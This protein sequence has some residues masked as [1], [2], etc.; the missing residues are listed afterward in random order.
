MNNA[1][2]GRAIVAAFDHVFLIALRAVVLVKRPKTTLRYMQLPHYA[3]P[4][5]PALPRTINDLFYWRKLFDDDPRFPIIADKLRV[6]DWLRERGIAV[7]TPEIA[8][9]GTDPDD[10][11]DALWSADYVLKANH[12]SGWNI[13]L[14]DHLPDRGSPT[15]LARRFIKQ[16]YGAHWQEP[17]YRDIEPKLYLER[18]IP[19]CPSEVKFYTIGDQVPRVF[20]SY[21]RDTDYKADIWTEDANGVLVL[22]EEFATSVEKRAGHPVP[23]IANEALAIAR[24][25]GRQFDHVRVDFL[26]DG[27]QF[28]FSELTLANLGGHMQGAQGPLID[29]ME[30]AWDIRRSWFMQTPQTGWRKWYQAAL[31]RRLEARQ[32]QRS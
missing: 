3:W 29:R 31:R 23:D 5:N 24:S 26:T 28:W 6:A 17:F 19:N 22:T 9:I 21:D 7:S 10:I 12:G 14:K 16:T 8:W 1:P 27:E 4:P 2:L 11:P 15:R 25:I 13:F 18:L 20:V 32:A 30:A